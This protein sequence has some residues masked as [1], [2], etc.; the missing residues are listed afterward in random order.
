M[1]RQQMW[2][3]EE[4]KLLSTAIGLST[5]S[6]LQGCEEA[7]KLLRKYGF[8]RTPKAC[9]LHYIKVIRMKNH[10]IIIEEKHE[11]QDAPTPVVAVVVAQKK[12]LETAKLYKTLLI[13][14]VKS[15]EA[16]ISDLEALDK[17]ISNNK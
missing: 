8:K 13:K 1:N 7:S 5:K 15:T 17:F 16:F 9:Y 11:K 4:N 2:T 10:S 6:L 3:T 14:S 12:L